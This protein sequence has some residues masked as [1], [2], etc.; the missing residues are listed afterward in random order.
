MMA[1]KTKLEMAK[2]RIAEWEARVMKQQVLVA[3][4]AA[5]ARP[6]GDAEKLLAGM[7]DTLREMRTD[8]DRLSGRETYWAENSPADAGSGTP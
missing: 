5:H 4:L 7:V 8:L 6:T 2:R 3:G 1:N